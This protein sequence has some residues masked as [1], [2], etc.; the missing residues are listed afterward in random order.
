MHELTYVPLTEE[1]TPA[2]GSLVY[3]VMTN[4]RIM[5]TINE[6]HTVGMRCAIIVVQEKGVLREVT[7]VTQ[8][9]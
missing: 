2:A 9:T 1:E 4:E 3:G 5:E 8:R 6:F 7:F